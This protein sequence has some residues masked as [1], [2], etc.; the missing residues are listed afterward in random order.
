MTLQI[1]EPGRNCTGGSVVEING[2]DA[3]IVLSIRQW[4][5]MANLGYSTAKKVLREG[6][7][8]R[9]TRLTM[10]R[11]GITLSSHREWLRERTEG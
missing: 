9:K 8:P 10:H 3:E 4:A 11:V 5:L 2:A 1:R 7:G 6:N